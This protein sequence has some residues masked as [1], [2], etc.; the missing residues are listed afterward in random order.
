MTAPWWQ[1]AVIY[2]IYPRSFQDS[3]GDGIGDLG[4]IIQRLPYLA[5]LGVN[6]LWLT[7]VFRS[8]MADF[9]YDISNYTDIDPVFGTLADFDA[10]LAEAHRRGMKIMLDFVP[11]HTSD[12]HPWF[13][14]SRSS[15]NAAS[16]TGISGATRRRMAGRRT[17]GS[18]VRRQRLGIRQQNRQY[19]YH[20]FLKQQPDL[21]WRNP[22]VLEAMLRARCIS[23]SIAASTGS[24]S[25]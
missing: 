13:V 24:A 12:Q 2:E 4:G 18:A 14:D 16:A 25:M 21:N 20:A 1:T 22:E 11:N 3:D 15:R 10:L 8:P 9:G 5:E 19:Y 7:P 17:I 23:G 6:A